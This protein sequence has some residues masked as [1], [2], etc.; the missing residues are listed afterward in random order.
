MEEENKQPE[1]VEVIEEQFS[2]TPLYWAWGFIVLATIFDYGFEQVSC[3]NGFAVE[4]SG[5][6][7]TNL[8]FGFIAAVILMSNWSSITKSPEEENQT[9]WGAYAAAA[10][11]TGLLFTA[12]DGV[13]CRC[14]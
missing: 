14:W 13:G 11:C 7:F 12:F 9:R 10:A 6:D 5:I 3:R 8:G 4:C 2:S 1:E